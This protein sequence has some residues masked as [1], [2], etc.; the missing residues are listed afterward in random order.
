MAFMDF[1]TVMVDTKSG[2]LFLLKQNKRW[3]PYNKAKNRCPNNER[4][5]PW[6]PVLVAVD[7]LW[8]QE[9]SG[10]EDTTGGLRPRKSL[11]PTTIHLPANAL[12]V[13]P[14]LT[15]KNLAFAPFA[16]AGPSGFMM[17]NLSATTSSG[18]KQDQALEPKGL[19]FSALYGLAARARGKPSAPL[20]HLGHVSRSS[21]GLFTTVTRGQAQKP[22]WTPYGNETSREWKR[23]SLCSFTR[24]YDLCCLPC[25]SMGEPSMLK[26]LMVSNNEKKRNLGKSFCSYGYS[27]WRH[28]KHQITMKDFLH[29]HIHHYLNGLHLYCRLVKVVPKK[30]AR[31]IILFWERTKLYARMYP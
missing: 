6:K 13:Q 4:R 8:T 1:A 2:S 7:W 5:P 26:Y 29:H 16:S 18:H 17:T 23:T 24:L 10:D 27:H 21:R 3:S 11:K 22:V 12:F 9:K 30:Y 25:L 20:G 14:G 28:G 19:C 15:P 31:V